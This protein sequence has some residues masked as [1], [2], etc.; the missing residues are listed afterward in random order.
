MIDGSRCPECGGY[1]ATENGTDYECVDCET[2][3]D[4]SDLFLP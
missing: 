4:V 2:D 3:F 1:V